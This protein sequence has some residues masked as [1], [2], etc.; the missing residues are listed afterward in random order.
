[1]AVSLATVTTGY[2]S[3]AVAETVEGLQGI[4]Q[5]AQ[6]FMSY[7]GAPSAK[8]VIDIVMEGGKISIYADLHNAPSK[9]DMQKYTN[10]LGND[11]GAPAVPGSNE[12]GHGGTAGFHSDAKVG[13]LGG[14]VRQ[15]RRAP[16]PSRSHAHASRQAAGMFMLAFPLTSGMSGYMAKKPLIQGVGAGQVKYAGKKAVNIVV[17]CQRTNAMDEDAGAY[18]TFIPK[19]EAE[20]IDPAHYEH[21]VKW[22][23]GFL[24]SVG[25][26]LKGAFAATFDK[27]KDTNGLCVHYHEL[28]DHGFATQAFEDGV[29]ND[30]VIN[31][32]PP[33]RLSHEIAKQFDVNA[34]NGRQF[35]ING[36]VVDL[37]PLCPTAQPKIF[38]PFTVTVPGGTVSVTLYSNDHVD[39]A[40]GAIICKFG[41]LLLSEHIQ[42]DGLASIRMTL[43]PGARFSGN[44][45]FTMTNRGALTPA[46]LNM[47]LAAA[48]KKDTMNMSASQLALQLPQRLREF[49][50]ETCEL[51][52]AQGFG[53]DW[54]RML[55]GLQHAYIVVDVGHKFTT[56]SFKTGLFDPLAAS[57]A[58]LEK[59]LIPLWIARCDALPSN[60][61]AQL[62]AFRKAKKAEKA[63]KMDSNK[64]A[65]SAKVAAQLGAAGG[66][67][68]GDGEV[69]PSGRT[70]RAAAVAAKKRL[71]EDDTQPMPEPPPPPPRAPKR[72]KTAAGAAA[73]GNPLALA[74]PAGDAALRA[75]NDRLKAQ[76]AAHTAPAALTAPTAALAAENERLRARLAA[77]EAPAPAR[78][79]PAQLE[80]LKAREAALA[81]RVAALEAQLQAA[82]IPPTNTGVL[83]LTNGAGVAGEHIM[84]E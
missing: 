75:E 2:L 55:F 37:K 73:P 10:S 47:V 43:K 72:A 12:K 45:G 39:I 83:A 3:G 19:E 58:I 11:P 56:N 42:D 52:A 27:L 61:K 68:G 64:K 71:V 9:E 6:N 53:R 82:G 84:I 21:A 31:V 70:V 78:A 29:T 8:S 26:S 18:E 30:I 23:D 4:L 46:F 20:Q 41:D 33:L 60:Y 66:A 35:R 63:A 7:Q 49:V 24:R 22:L 36:Q 48:G 81:A 51:D 57:H 16:P 79:T 28:Q 74:Q 65:K 80:R 54:L 67:A 17:Y 50:K 38:G 40:D 77:L 15:Q 76:L 69:Q 62:D 34:L 1:M 5:H 25:T 13:L 44:T 14:K 59:A 32:D